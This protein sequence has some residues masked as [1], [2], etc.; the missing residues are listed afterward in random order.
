MKYK[1]LKLN[2]SKIHNRHCGTLH[3]KKILAIP[4]RLAESLLLYWILASE[5]W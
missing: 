2:K 1:F 5:N 3:P 4:L